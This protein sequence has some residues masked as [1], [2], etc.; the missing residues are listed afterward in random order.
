MLTFK[1]VEKLTPVTQ[2]IVALKHIVSEKSD[3]SMRTASTATAISLATVLFF[4]QPI[5]ALADDTEVFFG[6][7]DQSQQIKPNVLFALDT[8]GSMSWGADDPG[9]TEPRIT[10]MKR[11]L[12]DILRGATNLNIGLMRFNGSYGGGPILYPI[13]DIDTE[14]CGGQN[15]GAITDLTRIDSADDDGSE[16]L[17]NNNVDLDNN[18]LFLGE[19]NNDKDQR[20]ALRFAQLNI[21]SGAVITSAH[22]EFVA[23][24]NS[25]GNSDL[26]ITAQSIDDSPELDDNNRNLTNRLT[27]GLQKAWN[28]PNWNNNQTYQSEDIS[29]LIQPIINRSGW[30][31]RN[32]LTVMIEGKGTR[33]AASADQDTNLAPA[34]RVTYDASS[35]A[36]N[37]GCAARVVVS[38]IR[39]K[40]DD[41]EEFTWWGIMRLND[42]HMEL[43]RN[44]IYPQM[45]GY[46]FQDIAVPKNATIKSAHLEFEIA[47][48]QSN[49]VTMTIWGESTDNPQP[50]A[51]YWRNISNRPRT[52][53]AEPWVNPPALGQNSTLTTPDLKD[54]VQ[55]LVDRGGWIEG[56]AMAFM[57]AGSGGS[58]RRIVE[59][60]DGEPSNAPRLR[61]EYESEG[62]NRLTVRDELIEQ[63]D[64]LRTGGFTPILDVMYEGGQYFRGKPVEFGTSRG[65]IRNNVDYRHQF[66]RVSHPDSYTGGAVDRS[67]ACTSHGSEDSNCR[68]ETITGSA[69]YI[70]PMTSSCQTNHLVVLSDGVPN[71]QDSVDRVKQLTGI[72][73]C[74]EGGDEAC[75]AELATWLAENDHHTGLS[76]T[77]NVTTYTIGFG[78]PQD[79]EFLEAISTA[80]NGRHFEA[81]SSEDLQEAFG[82]ILSDVLDTSTSFVAPGA[83]VNQFNRLTHRDDIYF[84]LFSPQESPLWDGNL[85]KY[86]IAT[87]PERTVEIVDANGNPAVDAESGFFSSEATSLWSNVKDGNDVDRGG[88]AGQLELSY[89]VTGDRNVYTYTGNAAP[90]NVDLTAAANQLHESNTTITKNM[91]GIDWE[92]DDYK[93]TLLQWARGV[94]VK[95]EDNDNDLTDVRN[96]IGDPMHSR[97]LIV[98]Y[99]SGSADEVDSTIYVATN[100]GMLH[101]IDHKTGHEQFS[102]IPKELLPNLNQ[103]YEEDTTVTHPYGLDGQISIWHDDTNNNSLVDT[104]EAAYIFIGMRRGGSSYYALDI[105]NR[106]KP[107]LKWVI[108]GGGIDNNTPTPGFEQ[109]SQSWSLANVSRIHHNSQDGHPVLIFGAGYSTN[110]DDERNVATRPRREDNIGRGFF[111]V[112]VETGERIWSVS[113]PL[114]AGTPAIANHTI[115]AD[116]NYSMP[117]DIRVL[118]LDRDD[119]ADQ[120]YVGDMGGQIWR[121]DFDYQ[122]VSGDLIQG[123]V[124]ADFSVA[125]SSEDARRFYYEPDTATISHDGIRYLSLGIGSGWRAHPLDDVVEDRFYMLRLPLELGLP[126]GYGKPVSTNGTTTTYTPITETDLLDVSDIAQPAESDILAHNGWLIKFPNVG[127]KVL[128]DALTVS[129]QLIFTTYKP[130]L[131]VGVCGTAAGGGSIYAVSAFDGSPTVDFSGSGEDRQHLTTDDRSADLQHGGIPPEPSALVAE[132]PDGSPISVITAGTELIHGIEV[133]NTTQKTWWQEAHTD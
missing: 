40:N 64:N 44:G 49:N 55:E 30:C 101:A 70:S 69:R 63:V 38:Q 54:I 51:N 5:S 8:S 99:N 1:F 19:D 2:S 128:G 45:A 127:E 14:I 29:N 106:A 94:D 15:C 61:I 87:T 104:N 76:G 35:V 133:K 120:M 97:P 17:S 48:Q 23:D 20:V 81:V 52:T 18:T 10:R 58:G 130:D 92:S 132:A 118:D 62:F 83:T 124:I 31:G 131:D 34:L 33:R 114:A 36:E 7:V 42:H 84:S 117:S 27:G 116:M 21:P 125:G 47:Q 77:Q 57:I 66:H 122:R 90:I 73:N 65:K 126:E 112:D 13:T 32:A 79:L 25:T 80:G 93:T 110:Q 123:G 129:N 111:V 68:T 82:R 108:H 75:I 24:G 22:L 113:G 28:P 98:N 41:A 59:S 105:S 95:D 46:R 26:T 109:L 100:E 74:A 53:A 6:Q 50:Y 72:A 71:R 78:R 119:N 12:V 88:A 103:F 16:R 3:A 107:K 60:I 121:F 4:G 56:N 102:F 11:A 86:R 67:A 91:L 9:A 43:S 37:E 115:F 39:Q 89:P 85:K 96:H